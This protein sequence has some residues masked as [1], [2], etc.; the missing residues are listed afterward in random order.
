MLSRVLVEAL[1]SIGC[2]VTLACGDEG[3]QAFK[4]HLRRDFD[5]WAKALEVPIVVGFHDQRRPG[6]T[7]IIPATMPLLSR[8]EAGTANGPVEACAELALR[9]RSRLLLIVQST[10]LTVQHLRRLLSLARFPWVTVMPLTPDW[11]GRTR[12]EMIDSFCE[13]IMDHLRVPFKPATKVKKIPPG[14]KATKK[15]AEAYAKAWSGHT[16]KPRTAVGQDS[17]LWK[18]MTQARQMAD[19]L[20]MGYA[21][22]VQAQ[23][24]G[25]QAFRENAFP[26]PN[27]LHTA[28]A[29]SRA[30]R[31]NEGGTVSNT[32]L[33]LDER[34]IFGVQAIT[35]GTADLDQARY[36]AR[37][38]RNARGSVHPKVRAYVSLKEKEDGNRG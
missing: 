12:T 11:S 17:K 15:F 6:P 23:V 34:Y 8:I 19:R 10:P 35:A 33:R 2:T 32:D 16:G 21:E 5:K 38:Q 20:R 30:I 22:F 36:V 25:I 31:W 26:F 28:Q 9:E 29:E 3:R 1:H 24:E 27:Q 7:V 37:C 13:R 14:I 4:K 18:D